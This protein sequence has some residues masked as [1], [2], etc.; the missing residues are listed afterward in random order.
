[1]HRKWLEEEPLVSVQDAPRAEQ[2]RRDDRFA[3]FCGHATAGANGDS[4]VH[5]SRATS[6]SGRDGASCALRAVAQSVHCGAR[7]PAASEFR[8]RRLV[9]TCAPVSKGAARSRSAASS[10]H[11]SRAAAEAA[12]GDGCRH[13]SAGS[14]G[15]REAQLE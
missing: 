6:G 9:G 11:L 7:S 10:P 5:A 4:Q 2:T 13:H 15:P 12:A 8:T 3:G 14:A 1:M